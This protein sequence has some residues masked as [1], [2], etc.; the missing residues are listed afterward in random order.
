MCQRTQTPLRHVSFSLKEFRLLAC[1][2]RK[3]ALCLVPELSHYSR[4]KVKWKRGKIKDKSHTH[5]EGVARRKIAFNLYA[6][7]CSRFAPSV[8]TL[9]KCPTPALNL[10][11][12]G[13]LVTVSSF[14][15]VSWVFSSWRH[16]R[17][18]R[19]WMR[20]EDCHFV[21][22]GEACERSQLTQETSEK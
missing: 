8:T 18:Y 3:G 9:I 4:V 17:G 19:N 6:I 10:V 7:V 12:G 16:V 20:T 15:S 11:Y 5:D 13:V 14:Q 22:K 21:N 1:Q 2:G